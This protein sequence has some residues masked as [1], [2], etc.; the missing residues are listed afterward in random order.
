[1][2][3]D[4]K[5][6]AKACGAADGC[7]VATEL[8]RGQIER[9]E[10]ALR[11][12]AGAPLIVACTQESATFEQIAEDA[13]API[14][15]FINIREAAGWSDDGAAVLPKIAALIKAASDAAPAT[16]SLTL[17]SAG[18]CLIYADGVTRQ[19]RR[20]R[21]GPCGEAEIVT[22]CH[23]DDQQSRPGHHADS[24]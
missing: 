14:P 23:R 4:A 5:K 2:D 20:R 17:T 9:F 22:R 8:C 18:R 7:E 13:G 15:D 11:E 1:M 10:A 3:I 24:G 12:N 21:D 6:L 19:R 16:R